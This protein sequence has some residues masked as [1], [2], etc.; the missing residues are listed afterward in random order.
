[1]QPILYSSVTEG[2]VPAHY[3]V[4]VLSDCISCKVT[5]ERNGAFELVMTYAAEG[6][7]ASDIQ[8]NA[9][10][11][12]K[13]NFT[14][15]PQLFRIYKVG[16]V[17]DGRFEVYAQ[18]ISYDLSGKLITTGSAGSCVAAC[19]LLEAQAGNFTITTDKSVTANFRVSEPSSVR[20]WFGGK[21]GSL[22]DVYGGEWA[23]DNYTASLKQA[24]GSDRGV[25]IRYG[26]N[27][28][29]LSQEL[30]ME[31]LCTGVVPYY[32][33][34]DGN[35]TVGAKVLTGLSLDVPRDLAVDFSSDVNPESS[36]PILTQ[37]ATLAT[38]YVSKRNLTSPT[39][40]IE[41][42]FVQIAE[43]QERVDLCDT[44][45]IYFEALGLSA[46]AKCIKTEWDVLEER[47]TSTTFG[48]AR[49]NIA[50]TIVEQQRAVELKP[51]S[52]MMDQ[53]IE[54]ATKLITGNLGGFVVIH[55]SNNDGEPDEILIMDTPDISTS[56]AIWRWNKN[57]LGYANSYSGPYGL[58]MTADGEI[59]A[60]FI[61]TGTM[62]ANRVRTGMISSTN[63]LLQ[64][65]LD[66]GTITAPSI[67]LNGE[68]VE[69]TLESLV[70]TSVVS[71]YA[72]SNSGTSIPSAFPLNAPTQ[73]TEAQPF[74]WTKT[75]YTY[76][77]GQ[78]NTSYAISVRGQNGQNGQ[79][80]HGLQILG[81]YNSMAELIAAHPTGSAG[82]VYMVGTDLVVWNTQTNSWEDV[83]RI[84][85]PSGADGLWL[86][87]DNDDNGTNMSV[88]YTAH[89]M[90]GLTTDATALYNTVFVW[91]LVNEDGVEQLA[92]AT[93]TITVARDSAKYGSVI[94]C[95]CIAVV[96][97]EGLQDYSYTTI[98]DYQG[99]D[100]T[101]IGS[102]S[103]K[104]IGECAIYKPYAISAQFQVL[105]DEISS[106]VS[107]TD[108]NSLSG[109]V[110]QQG[111]LIQ[112]NANAIAL[113][114]D[115]TTVN[116]LSGTVTSQGTA[117][118]Q[119]AQAITLKADT[120]T[121]NSQL[122]GKMATDMS[123]RSSSITINS[124]EIKFES[125]TVSISATN[126]TVTKTGSVTAVNFMAK[127]LLR[128]V[129]D[130]NV[131]LASIEPTANGGMVAV[132]MIDTTQ[133]GTL[134][135]LADGGHFA[136]SNSS[137]KVT[138]SLSGANGYLSLGNSSGT[139]TIT[140]SGET[141]NITATGK[142]TA[143]S[144]GAINSSGAISATGDVNGTTLRAT[145]NVVAS[146]AILSGGMTATGAIACGGITA[147]TQIVA[148]DSS[149]NTRGFFN[150]GT[151]GYGAFKNYNGDNNIYLRGDTGNVECVSV[152]Q[153][154]SRKVKENIKPIEDSEKI[155]LLDAVSFDYKDRE[156]GTDKRGFIA[157]DVAEVLPN[158]V[159]PETEDRPASLDYVSMI[160]Y[161]QDVIKKQAKLIEDLERRIS[162]LEQEEK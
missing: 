30:N 1:M 144:F 23:Y 151:Y 105:S 13:P 112:Q 99:N 73:P 138:V 118:T 14:D 64:I 120:A 11:K 143:S 32:V 107:Q 71:T 47:Y 127:R 134:W 126:L 72:L 92:T 61:T 160:P 135:A 36:T 56:T 156:R 38:N 145:G 42:D 111:T 34:S 125:N 136:L 78:S 33:D 80:G 21:A 70:Q 133:V 9:I 100:I 121:V 146:G 149:G 37:L 142:I 51:S 10:L 123:N 150:A 48:D 17:I 159:A 5:E 130:N 157:E 41:L 114:A 102:N 90:K 115:Q 82:D 22:L 86:A 103:V 31:N 25:E 117:I 97:E 57:G 108:F 85:G 55:D 45:H 158:L 63:N 128:V 91:D 131:V 62:S 15:N 110:T 2:T 52:S 54:R 67:T 69:T 154:S 76:A 122:G 77:N 40:S 129:N 89:L 116:T 20:S 44:V 28:T 53:A 141:G 29:N 58:A 18:H 19:A 162:A 119:N 7:H 68:D 106:K 124:G 81:N 43:L 83:G 104:L 95:I 155:L 66:A 24:R 147:K 6:L 152:T 96:D 59:V 12:A 75:V 46:T 35:Q 39:D 101:I 88:T 113:K 74:L 65:D 60:D 84:Q 109:T 161:L 4:G 26:K 140:A 137:K 50:D 49:T 148:A 98:Q 79:D 93:P 139:Q 27:L 3:G 87:I 16:K 153:T 132:G 8:V 94:R